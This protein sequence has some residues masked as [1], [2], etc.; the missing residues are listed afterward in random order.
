MAVTAHLTAA[1]L[2]CCLEDVFDDGT[3]SNVIA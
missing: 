2:G 3:K 1:S